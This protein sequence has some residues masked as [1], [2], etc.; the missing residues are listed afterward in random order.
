MKDLAVFVVEKALEMGA[1][2][3]DIRIELVDTV[4]LKISNGVVEKSPIGYS[5]GA[6]ITVLSNGSWGFSTS[7][8]LDKERLL[9]AVEFAVKVAKSVGD[10]TKEKVKLV[11]VEA[12]EDRIVKLGKKKLS[13]IPVDEKLELA[14]EADRRMRNFDP[15][16]KTGEVTY[17][18]WYGRK[19]FYSSLGSYIEWEFSRCYSSFNAVASENGKIQSFITRIAHYGGYE[20]F[21]SQ[22]PLEKALEAA[23]K[24]CNLLKAVPVKGGRY[25]VIADPEHIGVFAHE[26]VGH[27]CEA[28]LV[29]AGESVLAGKLGEKI[30][31]DLVTI[32]DDSTIDWWGSEKY[33]DEG[34]KTQ[35]RKLIDRGVLVGYMLNRESAAKL[36]MKPNGSARAMTFKHK[37]IVRMSNTYIAPGDYNFEELLEDIELGVYVK[38]SRGGQ[39]NPAVGGFQFNAQEAYLIEKGEITKPLLDV[40]LSGVILE[41][42][43]NVDA[44]G[45]D[46]SLDVGFC[47]KDGQAIPVGDGGP[48]VRI[49]NVVVGGRA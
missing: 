25:T 8:K 47:G 41:T 20:G 6:G 19:V 45:K 29:I 40:S 9:D 37:P 42:L 26:A 46:L 14:L 15:R 23:R 18:E 3:A 1:E 13:D 28:D 24:A 22:K 11:D 2:Y 33:D 35:K 32:Y 17:T 30:G 5:V 38:G 43:K 16:V 44:V 34:V 21:E 49:R 12:V 36:G 7:T 27:A 10:R 39:V 4:R 31:S 48:H